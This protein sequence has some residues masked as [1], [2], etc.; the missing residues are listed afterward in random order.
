MR[1]AGIIEDLALGDE[2]LCGVKGLGA[3]LRV[4]KNR[5]QTLLTGQLQCDAQQGAANTLV[6]M[7][8]ANRHATDLPVGQQARA[9]DGMIC[10]I[11]SQQVG[12]NGVVLVD[13][14]LLRHTLFFDEDLQTNRQQAGLIGLP[15]G[16]VDTVVVSHRESAGPC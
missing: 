9:A 16:Y 11:K 13:L 2:A 10:G 14:K 3:A 4:Q 15:V 12:G 5:R 7:L 6:A 1:N 8:A